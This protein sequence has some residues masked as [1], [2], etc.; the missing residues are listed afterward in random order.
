MRG[1][2]VFHENGVKLGEF[3]QEPDGQ[4]YFWPTAQGAWSFWIL[5]QIAGYLRTFNKY[6]L[7][8]GGRSPAPVS[9]NIG[10]QSL[11]PKEN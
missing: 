7:N 2:E 4:Y 10:E 1:F 8:R 5:E 3:A 11:N 6:T 9:A